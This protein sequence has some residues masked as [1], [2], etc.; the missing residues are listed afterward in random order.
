MGITHDRPDALVRLACFDPNTG[1]ELG[2]YTAI[3]E[4]LSESEQ[5]RAEAE[6]RAEVEHRRA[7]AEA[8]A[9]AAAD[10]RVRALE[11]ELKQSRGRKS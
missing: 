2:D 5:R 3:S 6:A 1:Q 8:R 11:A 4:A 9:R 10:E 7:L